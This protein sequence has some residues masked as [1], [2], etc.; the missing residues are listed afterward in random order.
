MAFDGFVT[1]SIVKELQNNII[2]SK[3]N[4]ILEPTKNDIILSLYKNGI[5]YSLL[6]NISS[7]FC[8]I[9]LTKYSKPNPQ[10]AYNFC[11]LLRKYLLNS[12]IISITSI[13]LERTIEIDFE[14]YNELNDLVIRKLYIEIM[15]RQSNI[16]FTNENNIIIDT[17]KHVNTDLRKL[18]PANPY[19]EVTSAK[20]SFIKI[21]SFEYFFDIINSKRAS[22]NLLNVLT[23][24][25]IGFSKSFI[26][27][28]LIEL[29]I[30]TNDFDKNDIQKLYNYLKTLLECI[31]TNDVHCKKISEKDYV[32]SINQEPQVREFPTNDFIDDFYHNKEEEIEFVNTRNN[33]LKIVSSYLKKVYKKVE[34][35]NSKLKECEN[36]DTYKL[37]GELL[38][39]NLYKLNS[40]DNFE[41]IELE[42]YY[43]NNN[44]IK[45]PL[46]KSLSIK[47]NIDKYFKKY[48]KLKNAL[49]VISDQ[50]READQELNYI[51]SIVF[52]L[53]NAKNLYDLNEI[54]EEMVMTL[55]IK[56]KQIQKNES[57][58]KNTD[59]PNLNSIEFK[60]YTI[61]IGKN[62]IQNDYISIRMSKSNDIWFHAQK[63]HGCHVLL[64]NPNNVEIDEIPDDVLYKCAEFAKQNSKAEK[65]VNVPIDYCYAKYVKKPSGSKPGMVIYNNFKTIIVK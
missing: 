63:I 64:K 41:S 23:S 10:T 11:M 38:T 45:I 56:S 8:R 21:N 46:N 14:C 28:I 58:K 60:G 31:E 6:L 19:E 65:S 18:L 16:I 3:V 42:N 34:N 62:N 24:S 20:E 61:Y 49:L 15:S 57:S 32:I 1:K 43:D 22:N 9:N 44:A 51:N 13:D 54:Y 55:K 12:K 40:D 30:P 7:D 39:A 25:F 26:Q 27:N 5:N 2:D 47:E 33:L 17:I 53:G 35:I 37:Y 48:N 59:K 4:K 52:L 29:N 50:K 36:K